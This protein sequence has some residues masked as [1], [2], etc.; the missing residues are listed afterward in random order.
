MEKYLVSIEFRYKDADRS[1]EDYNNRS[2][3]VTIGVYDNFDNA[4]DAGNR[5]LEKLEGKFKLHKFPDGSYASKTKNRFSLRGGC[6]GSKQD[7]ITDLAYLKTPFNFYAKITTLNIDP[8]EDVL[9]TIKGANQRRESLELES[10][11]LYDKAFKHMLEELVVISK[12]EGIDISSMYYNKVVQDGVE[13]SVGNPVFEQVTETISWCESNFGLTPSFKII[14]GV[15]YLNNDVLIGEHYE[16][17]KR[18]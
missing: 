11:V 13:L 10:K 18:V 17:M 9:E 7:L 8:V 14:E 5:L 4:C 2:K 12:T 1:G 3:T 16:W 15:V 6:F